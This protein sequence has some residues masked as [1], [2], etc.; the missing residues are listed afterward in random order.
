VTLVVEPDLLAQ[1][2]AAAMSQIR[3]ARNQVSEMVV[4]LQAV[5][6]SRP[7]SADLLTNGHIFL[8]TDSRITP[9]FS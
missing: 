7:R 5:K 3:T 4:E 6:P 1:G 8:S 2:S 9:S